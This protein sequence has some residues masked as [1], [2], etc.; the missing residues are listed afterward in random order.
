MKNGAVLF[1]TLFLL[2][3]C[4]SSS[5]LPLCTDQVVITGVEKKLLNGE[6]FK[7]RVYKDALKTQMLDIL[8]TKKVDINT[9]FN[10]IKLNIIPSD[11]E[12]K[13]DNQSKT[14]VCTATVNVTKG[15]FKSSYDITYQFSSNLIDQQ[16]HEY[17]ITVL[18][19]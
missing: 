14:R 9:I 13:I 5:N 4:S 12:G 10:D 19:K 17:I 7:Q 15:N 8:S 16:T 6:E 1:I 18:V 2:F 11:K 3:A